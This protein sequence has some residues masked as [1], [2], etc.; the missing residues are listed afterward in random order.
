M[1]KETG[2]LTGE[3]AQP[4]CVTQCP[5]TSGV[6]SSHIGRVYLRLPGS[7]LA[8]SLFMINSDWGE[9]TS[10]GGLFPAMKIQREENA[11]ASRI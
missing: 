8:P 4:T 9:L 10:S 3:K 2:N 7:P 1:R 6:H 11:L 5:A